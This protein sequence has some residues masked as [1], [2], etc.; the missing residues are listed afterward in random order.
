MNDDLDVLM[1]VIGIVSEQMPGVTVG[2]ALP[3]LDDLDA[4]L[5]CV[6]IDV[7]PGEQRA[8]AWGGEDFPVRLDGVPLD[9]EV[10]APSRAQAMQVAKRLR[11]VLHQLPH[12]AGTDVTDVDCPA[13]GSRED[14]N[15]NVR[16]VGIICDLTLHS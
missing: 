14:L 4:M 7:L 13:F 10:F 3:P 16:A 1:Q 12:I 6:T 9:V 11:L 8:V 15:P 2:D 5:P